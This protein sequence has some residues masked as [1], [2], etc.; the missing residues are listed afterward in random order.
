MSA[1]D[2]NAKKQVQDMY[3][4]IAD[5][6]N[7]EE[8]L[9]KGGG[10][11]VPEA[12]SALYFIDRKIRKA[13]ELSRPEPDWKAHEIGCS[14][15]QMTALLA[16]HFKK[17]TA[18]D[19]SEKCVLLADKRLKL[20][21]ITNIDFIQADAESMP[22]VPDDS[23]DVIY[24]FSAIRYCPNPDEALKEIYRTLKPGGVMVVDFPNSYS[25]WHRIIKPLLG[26]SPH[27]H[28][29]LFSARIVSEMARAAGFEDVRHVHFLFTYRGE[30][31]FLLPFTKFMDVVFERIPLLRSLAGI[32]M[33]AGRKP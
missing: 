6:Y 3:D 14:L 23:F 18:S 2:T 5:E 25:P 30:P 11:R 16:R 12:R 1:T 4:G 21:G 10:A 29:H 20:Y 17:M 32:V 26:M 7:T 19:I 8:W 9:E 13:L 31:D 22:H 27:I 28:A 33:V 15:G 24:S